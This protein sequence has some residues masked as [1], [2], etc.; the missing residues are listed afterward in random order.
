VSATLRTS[1][2][3]EWLGSADALWD[4]W[5]L[6]EMATELALY[7]WRTAPADERAAARADYVAALED[8]ERAAALLAWARTHNEP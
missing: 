1:P 8:E 6:A 4:T 5:V 3:E 2:C 7:L